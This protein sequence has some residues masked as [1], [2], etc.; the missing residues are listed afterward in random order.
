MWQIGLR[1]IDTLFPK[2]EKISTLESIKCDV[3]LVPDFGGYEK[4]VSH[5][6][7]MWWSKTADDMYNKI[8]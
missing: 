5:L 8:T 3:S 6:P 4:A 7:Q 2:N 1:Q